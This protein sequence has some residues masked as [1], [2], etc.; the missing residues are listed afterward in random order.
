MG[1]QRRILVPLSL[2]ALVMFGLSW[3]WHGLALNDLRDLTI[4]LG[5]Y[6]A[7]AA[8]AYL[9]IGAILTFSIH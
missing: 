6:I 5:L 2:S 1:L 7:L 3:V 8:V 9:I 4:P